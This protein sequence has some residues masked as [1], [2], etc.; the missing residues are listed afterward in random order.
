MNALTP[1]SRSERQTQT[2]RKSV[3][4]CPDCDRAAPLDDWS[5]T[6][7][8][9]DETVSCPDCEASLAVVRIA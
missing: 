3:L 8:A 5:R 4:F 1:R 6:A 9:G 7:D 2:L